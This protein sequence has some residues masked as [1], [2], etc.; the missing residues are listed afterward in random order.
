MQNYISLL[1]IYRCIKNNVPETTWVE[2]QFNSLPLTRANKTLFPP[3]NRLRVGMNI[4]S[5]RLSFA[6]TLIR[7]EDLNKEYG[8][9]KVMAK[10]IVINL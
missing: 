4:L 3:K 7:N 9:F 6:S 8:A 5:N 2:L 1:N 10:N